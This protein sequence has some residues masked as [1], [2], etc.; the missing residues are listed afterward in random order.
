MALKVQID[1]L[2][3]LYGLTAAQALLVASLHQGKMS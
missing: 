3:P 2:Q 1:R